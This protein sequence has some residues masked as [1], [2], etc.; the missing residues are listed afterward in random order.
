MIHYVIREVD[1]GEPIITQ[2][3]EIRPSDSLQN[4]QVDKIR[5]YVFRYTD[6][7]KKTYSFSIFAQDPS[8]LFV[9][10]LLSAK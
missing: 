9:V 4:L 5:A 1:R 7:T 6:N 8:R 3:V 10:F 2:E